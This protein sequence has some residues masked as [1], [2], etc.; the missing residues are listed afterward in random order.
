MIK[1]LL[2][3]AFLFCFVTGA[4]EVK[5][6]RVFHV[7]TS[8]H[9]SQAETLIRE[10]RLEEL[11][12]LHQSH[13]HSIAQNSAQGVNQQPLMDYTDEIYI[14]EIKLGTPP[15]TFS[16]GISTGGADSWVVDA[17][18]DASDEQNCRG[19]PSSGYSKRRFNIS[20]SST[21]VKGTTATKWV[22][23]T[24]YDAIDLAGMKFASQGFFVAKK[25]SQVFG[26]QPIDGILG[27]GW[28]ALSQ[29][30][31]TPP[32]WNMKDQM[33]EQTFTVF[34]ARNQKRLDK[35]TA[36]DGGRITFGGLDTDNCESQVD[37]MPNNS[38]M[39]WQFKMDDFSI[40]NWQ[41]KRSYSE[42]ILDT[43]TWYIGAPPEEVNYILVGT[44]AS[45]DTTYQ[46]YTLPCKGSKPD[47]VFKIGGIEYRVPAFEYM[48]DYGLADGK[49]ILAVSGAA[50]SMDKQT[51]YLG[52]PF[53][54][55]F[56][57][58][59]DI[60]KARVGFARSVNIDTTT[61][62][63]SSSSMILMVASTL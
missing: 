4:P 10:G 44:G 51:W 34:M 38:D 58:V 7:E 19:Q 6:R 30:K 29:N 56:C 16:V 35:T 33:D 45:W 47:M 54:R 3:S 60:E 13:G 2:V 46:M 8:R 55:Q 57:V 37:Y 1:F 17:V 41:A 28:P 27:L 63:S 20:A 25:V 23:T 40:G 50:E 15:Q 49:C 18:C 59:H 24:G 9:P 5:E 48:L 12:A 11:V 22:G 31:L 53:M 61:G 62:T 32:P 43:S 36:M 39:Y 26:T 52:A 21:F 14:G 42:V